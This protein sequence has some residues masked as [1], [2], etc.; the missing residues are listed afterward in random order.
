MG[1]NV[2][3]VT[4]RSVSLIVTGA[5]AAGTSSRR[6][7]RS[8]SDGRPSNGRATYA[9]TPSAEPWQFLYRRPEPHGQGW[10]GPT[11][12]SARSAARRGVRDFFAMAANL[13]V[14]QVQ[15]EAGPVGDDRPHAELEADLELVLGVHRPHV[16]L[17]AAVREAARE[18]GVPAQRR[19]PRPDD[20][21]V[22]DQRPQ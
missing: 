15:H 17:A 7:T 10:R 4:G 5:V 14:E 3:R 6:A 8:H 1:S 12:P 22:V 2:H 21:V 18:R 9:G 13:T 20:P 19:H 16:D 11:S